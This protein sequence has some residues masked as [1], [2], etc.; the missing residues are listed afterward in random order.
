MSYLDTNIHMVYLITVVT[1]D[2]I[3]V[4]EDEDLT[5]LVFMPS[6]PKDCWWQFLKF[7]GA[8]T[9][10]SFMAFNVMVYYLKLHNL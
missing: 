3:L 7:K 6:N 5:K 2:Y 4:H 10:M 8:Y 1:Y 9:K